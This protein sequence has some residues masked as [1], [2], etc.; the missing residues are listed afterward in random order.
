MARSILVV[1]DNRATV[2]VL[3]KLLKDGDCRVRVNYDRQYALDLVEHDVPDLMVSDISMPHV[4]GVTMTMRL[5]VSGLRIPIVLA[6]SE[7]REV[8]VSDVIFLTNPFDLDDLIEIVREMFADT[9]K[10][11]S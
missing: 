4:D 9:G 5:R 11:P 10:L 2:A 7:V 8:S 1:N 3:A 6:S